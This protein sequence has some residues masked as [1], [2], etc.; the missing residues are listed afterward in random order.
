MLDNN[1][2]QYST[3][4]EFEFPIMS[5]PIKIILGRWT[6]ESN[7]SLTKV[8]DFWCYDNNVRSLPPVS[9]S[10]KGNMFVLIVICLVRLWEVDYECITY[11]L[12][13][14]SQI[15]SALKFTL[16]PG[17]QPI[18]PSLPQKVGFRT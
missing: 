4:L 17:A 5:K 16:E 15:W 8:N 18:E 1:Y 11:V 9:E 2:L 3:V 13:S 6:R 14:P 7:N 12:L 10:T